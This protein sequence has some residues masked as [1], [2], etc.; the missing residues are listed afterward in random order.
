MALS[1]RSKPLLLGVSDTNAMSTG[2][3]GNRLGVSTVNCG[4]SGLFSGLGEVGSA[5]SQVLAVLLLLV[6]D[7]LVVGDISWIGHDSR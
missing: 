3:L 1:N 5:F 6:N 4:A 7:F 2:L